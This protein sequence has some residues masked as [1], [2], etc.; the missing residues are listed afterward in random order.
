MTPLITIQLPDAGLNA[1]IHRR[2][3][4]TP[5]SWIIR[6]SSK[7]S[8]RRP[9]KR[10]VY[11]LRTLLPGLA[12]IAML[13]AAMI[14]LG[15]SGGDWRAIAQ[16]ARPFFHAT[17]WV[18]LIVFSIMAAFYTSA[19]IKS[20]WAKK[21][22]GVLLATPVTPGGVVY[23]KFVGMIGR[24]LMFALSLLPVMAIWLHFGRVPKE[25]VLGGI[26]VI[27]G[28]AA[29]FGAIG[30]LES[31]TSSPTVKYGGPSAWLF[32]I[33][34]ILFLAP[35]ILP[36]PGRN[37]FIAAIPPWSMTYVLSVTAP[38][39][40]SPTAFTVLAVLAPIGIAGAVLLAARF[41]FKRSCRR[42]QG[43]RS[44]R[45]RARRRSPAIHRP[46]MGPTE[47]PLSWQERG[48]RPRSLIWG[49]GIIYVFVMA[50]VGLF[51]VVDGNPT[52]LNDPTIHLVLAS[53]AAFVLTLAAA[54]WCAETLAREKQ[55]RTAPFLV[56]TGRSP[57][58]FYKTKLF[59]FLHAIRPFYAF[60]LVPIL[61]A[62]L[63]G[64][65]TDRLSGASV[66]AGVVILFAG[67]AA[68]AVAAVTGLVFGAAANSPQQA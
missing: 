46:P 43:P 24:I 40:T 28:S 54:S 51:C 36:W 18:E 38:A 10:H 22:M 66:M 17:L 48:R 35:A 20:E 19:S 9:T 34:I 27:A 2:R 39:G 23:G 37:I 11:F 4:D 1:R 58:D 56:L 8:Y 63:L 49:W 57:G 15:A 52:P 45:E 53:L 6:S 42:Y 31:A 7:N 13:F 26:G 67:V 30:I 14:A 64:G 3:I 25:A 12:A 68:P 55:E 33:Y 62:F 50:L 21:T 29:L 60:I 61:L 16:I 5:C 41:V 44:P 59:A 65:I 32:L 47:H